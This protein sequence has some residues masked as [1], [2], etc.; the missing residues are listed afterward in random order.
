M[1]SKRILVLI[2]A[3]A[4]ALVGVIGVSAQD[5]MDGMARVRVAHFSVDAPAV[6]VFVNGDA[7]LTGV[8]Y[9]AM[10]GYLALPAGT[11]AVAVAPEGAGIEGA[12]IGPVDLEFAAGH[13]YT[14]AAI[15]QLAD[16]SFGPIVIDE[17]MAFGMAMEA[18]MSMEPT[19][20]VLVLHGISDAPAV[21]VALADGTILAEGLSFGAFTT[22][23]V[24][25]GE[26]PILVTASGDFETVVFDQLNPVNL[27]GDSLYFLAAIGTFPDNFNLFAQVTSTLTIAEIAVTAGSFETLVAALGAAD[28]AGLMADPAAGPFTVFAPVDEAFAALPEGTI[29]ALLADPS[30]AL[31]DI[32]LYHVVDGVAL[33]EDV[34]MLDSVTT[35]QGSPITIEVVGDG[36]VLNG[37]VNVII[38]NLIASNGVIH[39]I[40]AVLLPPE[41]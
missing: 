33:A 19:A 27:A 1:M 34:V 31:T 38:T 24:P 3:A 35:L 36:V 10:S 28:L 11:Y 16:E 18:E 2:L 14:V 32:L 30:G 26:Y 37:E 5:D 20:K 9:P 8:P 22:L 29:E 12:V 15:G 13:D 21:D 39:V 40:D 7:V 17:T 41:G 4:V 25:A 6:D 23:E